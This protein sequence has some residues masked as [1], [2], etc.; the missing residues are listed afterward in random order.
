M[1]E[2]RNMAGQLAALRDQVERTPRP[3]VYLGQN[4]VLTKTLFGNKILLDSRDKS[5]SPSLAL[6]G[7]WEPWITKVVMETIREGMTVIDAGANVGYYTLIAGSHV[8]PKG[9]VIAFEP[10]PELFELLFS[11][12]DINGFLDRCRC[13]RKALSDRAGKQTFY[14]YQSHMGGNTLYHLAGVETSLLD[15]VETI[16]VET[17]SLDDFLQ[18]SEDNTR[19]DVIKIDAEG[20]E[21]LIIEGMKRTLSDNDEITVI[22]EF[23]PERIRPSN[24]DPQAT[25]ATLLDLGFKLHYIDF[26]STIKPISAADLL[27]CKEVVLFLRRS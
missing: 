6:E 12:V 8:G 5:L 23:C 13:V 7:H 10:D 27:A 20:S 17:V 16:E 2:L 3:A 18:A 22:C 24:I 25:V 19:V 1:G 9:R 15:Q 14:R 26:D 11:G 4:R 21:G